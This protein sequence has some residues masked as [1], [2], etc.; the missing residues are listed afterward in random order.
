M[1]S[2]SRLEG[3]ANGET[4]PAARTGAGTPRRDDPPGCRRPRRRARGDADARRRGDAR[5]ASAAP[6]TATDAR[7]IVAEDIAACYCGEVRARADWAG[8]RHAPS[9]RIAQTNAP[10]GGAE[11]AGAVDVARQGDL[12]SRPSRPVFLGLMLPVSRGN[13]VDR[14]TRSKR[15]NLTVEDVRFHRKFGGRKA[16]ADHQLVCRSNLRRARALF[17]GCDCS[18]RRQV[19]S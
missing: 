4:S 16:R 13:L 15:R 10:R 7:G 8:R 3:T 1:S 11:L 14:R 19:T 9:S 2:S 6:G 5:Q 18:T 12:G 17:R